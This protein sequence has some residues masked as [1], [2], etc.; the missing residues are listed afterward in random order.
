MSS[1]LEI[2]IIFFSS[3][4]EN[5]EAILNKKG[6]NVI[7]TQSNESFEKECNCI[8]ALL[9]AQVDGIIA[10]IANETTDLTYYQKIKQKG[11][12][13]VLFDRGEDELDVDYISID[14]YNSSHKVIEHLVSQ[15]CKRIAHIAGFSH[16]RIYKERKVGY[17]DALKKHNLPIEDHLIIESNLRL[18]DGRRV[19]QQLLDLPERPDAV[20][21]AGDYA[22]LGALQVLQKNNIKVPED[23]ALIGFSNEPF[24]SFV[25]PSISTVDQHSEDMGRIAGRNLFKIDR[26]PY[27]KKYL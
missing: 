6:Y 26:K 21:V 25:S 17:K 15:G 5:I 13:L 3:V 12:P 10:S 22:A 16:I 24:T 18:E 8:D 27:Q 14:D 2:I 7:I 20:Y 19:M 23:I 1:F 11:T 9:S 4:V